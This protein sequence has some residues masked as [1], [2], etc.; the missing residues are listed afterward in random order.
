[1]ISFDCFSE[2][3]TMTDDEKLES[4]AKRLGIMT[5]QI[6]DIRKSGANPNSVLTQGLWDAI[7]KV[8]NEIEQLHKTL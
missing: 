6:D 5:K 3:M 8:A 2:G 7:D 1:M 4:L